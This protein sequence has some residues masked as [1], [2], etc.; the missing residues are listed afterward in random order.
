MKRRLFCLITLLGSVNAEAASIHLEL[1][2][3]QMSVAEYHRPYT[4]IW[5]EREDNSVA[6]NLAVWYQQEKAQKRTPAPP[7]S[8]S[9]SDSAKPVAVTRKPPAEKTVV[10][11]AGESGTQWLPDL[12]Q[13]WRRIGRSLTLPVDGVTGATRPPGSHTLSFDDQGALAKLAPGDYRL[14]VEAAREVGGRE[15][16]KLPFSWPPEQPTTIDA[17]GRSEL[18]RIVLELSP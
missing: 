14:V 3:P 13:W 15:L 4:A 11:D 12:R 16:M 17:K 6:A 2:L 5:I 7:A 1:T 9:S 8:A 18:G 10:A